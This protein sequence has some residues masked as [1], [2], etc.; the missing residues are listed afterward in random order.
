MHINTCIFN[1]ILIIASIERTIFFKDVVQLTVFS[2]MRENNWTWLLMQPVSYHEKKTLPNLRNTINT[3]KPSVL[4]P[5]Q[6]TDLLCIWTALFWPI[7][8]MIRYVRYFFPCTGLLKTHMDTVAT[9]GES[10]EVEVKRLV[11]R[12]LELLSEK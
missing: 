3:C 9:F 10:K 7:P 6:F 2:L 4:L 11:S 12:L 1:Y 5:S 8:M